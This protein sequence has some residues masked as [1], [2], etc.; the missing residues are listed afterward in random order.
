MAQLLLIIIV[1]EIIHGEKMYIDSLIDALNN[2]TVTYTKANGRKAATV[3][4][5]DAGD[6]ST[7]YEYNGIGELLT[8]TDPAGNQTKSVYNMS[9]RRISV[10]QPDAGLDGIY[11]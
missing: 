8:V 2:I 4:K 9:G 5:S 10:N 1:L 6:I 3:K 11:I 7:G